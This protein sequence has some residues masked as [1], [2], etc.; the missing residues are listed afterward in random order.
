M[1]SHLSLKEHPHTGIGRQ[2]SPSNPKHE[3]LCDLLGDHGDLLA[4]L[5]DPI[6][7]HFSWLSVAQ[8]DEFGLHPDT[9]AAV[10]WSNGCD[11]AETAE[12]RLQALTAVEAVQILTDT[13]SIALDHVLD[14]TD[15]A[16]AEDQPLDH[17]L[18]LNDS[19]RNAASAV[20]LLAASDGD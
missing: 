12:W 2:V 19:R 18:A 14:R 1:T 8:I 3:E 6:T 20:Q 5:G 10:Y 16:A 15:P 11:D 4:E 9:A 17:L 13:M 7:G